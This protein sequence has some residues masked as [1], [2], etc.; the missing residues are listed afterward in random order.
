MVNG[1]IFSINI[2]A[3]FIVD[4]QSTFEQNWPY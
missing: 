4:V 3:N 1:Q 2:N